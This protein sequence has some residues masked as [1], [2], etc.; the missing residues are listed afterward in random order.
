MLCIRVDGTYHRPV[1]ATAGCAAVEE[2]R[3]G[4]VDGQVPR[5]KLRA[6]QCRPAP[7]MVYRRTLPCSTST[8]SGDMIPL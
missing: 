4:G 2:G 3:I 7:V 1:D 5:G 8:S 6:R